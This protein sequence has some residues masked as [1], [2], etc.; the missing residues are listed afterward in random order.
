MNSKPGF[1]TEN[2]LLKSIICTLMK[3]NAR[4]QAVWE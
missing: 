4:E 3:I 2:T 1:R